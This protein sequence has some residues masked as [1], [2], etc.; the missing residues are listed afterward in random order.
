ME[1]DRP[2]I[3]NML[4]IFITKEEWIKHTLEGI[5]TYY[6][7]GNTERMLNF[8]EAW[9]YLEEEL[10]K[11]INAIC[12]LSVDLMDLQGKRTIQQKDWDFILKMLKK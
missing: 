4:S 2:E 1:Y 11:E 3:D 10:L 8:D 9:D 12:S 5:K 6:W 7:N